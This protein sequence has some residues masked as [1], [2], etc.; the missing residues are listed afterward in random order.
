MSFIQPERHPYFYRIFV[1]FIMKL[2]SYLLFICCLIATGTSSAQ[3]ADNIVE[4]TGV[5]MTADSLMAIPDVAVI[6]KTQDRGTYTN[7][8]G[9]FSIVC[10]GGDTLSFKMLGYRDVDYVIPQNNSSKYIHL[11][12]L[13]TQDTF[14]IPE[15]IV[16]IM[17][18]DDL[19]YAIR[20]N[21]APDD[22]YSIM[23]RNMS[24][25]SIRMLMTTMP[26][27]GDENQAAYQAQ[28]AYKATYYGQVQP[29]GIFDVF[30]WNEFF[31]AW[32][33]GDFKRQK[34]N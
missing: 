17:S 1:F 18:R 5:T 29:M 23:K 15:T 20:N 16:S 19:L 7:Y 31:Q 33:R 11:V 3:Q 30:K 34:N 21:L 24:P 32:K 27:S 13:M 28:Q 6:N 12:Q 2:I 25:E 22:S 9:V 8:M 10:N 26:R 14:Y 4:V